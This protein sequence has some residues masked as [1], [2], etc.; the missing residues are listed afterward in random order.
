MTL[1]PCVPTVSLATAAALSGLSVRTW[2]R[3]IED[4][5]VPRMTDAAGRPQIALTA[6]RTT[7]PTRDWGADD[8]HMLLRADQGEALAQA[9]TGAHFALCA[10]Q[11]SAGT[12]DAAARIALFFL[13]KAADQGDTEAMYWLSL[14]H[15]HAL[16]GAATGYEAQALMW[17]TKAAAQGHVIAQQHIHVMLTE[18]R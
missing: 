18:L 6:L 13:G 1:L 17:L 11:A 16:G 3:R 5:Q 15:A 12:Q 10:L 7:D 2:Q 14:L 4:G 9:E 8:V